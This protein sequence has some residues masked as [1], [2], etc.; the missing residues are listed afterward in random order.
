MDADYPDDLVLLANTHTQGKCLLYNMKH[1]E[2][3]IGFYLKSD[4]LEFLSFKESL[5][6]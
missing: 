6:G 2:S 1:A 5:C 4:K 3:N